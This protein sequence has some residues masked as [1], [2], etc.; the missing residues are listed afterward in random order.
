MLIFQTL[1]FEYRGIDILVQVTKVELIELGA[2][3]GEKRGLLLPK[4]TIL[5]TKAGDSNIKLQG[6]ASTSGNS[7][8]KPNFNFAD[9]GIGG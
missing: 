9:L 3:K 7:I 5:M 1:F 6:T 2:H 4:T 8:I